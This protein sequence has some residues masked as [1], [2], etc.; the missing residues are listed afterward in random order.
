MSAPEKCTS[1]FIETV[2]DDELVIV[3][4]NE[5]K[6]FSLKDTGLAIWGKIDGVRSRAEILAEL[7]EEYD[8]QPTE[9]KADMDGF[10]D[11][12]ASAGFVKFSR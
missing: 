5:G 2:V 11:E 8:A 10:L 6:F 9:I 12:L 3:S 1:A 4:L 7:A